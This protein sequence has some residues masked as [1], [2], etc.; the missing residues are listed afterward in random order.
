MLFP[1]ILNFKYKNVVAS[2]VLTFSISPRSN[3]PLVNI[4]KNR[5]EVTL[6]LYIALS[7]FF[8]SIRASRSL[9]ECGATGLDLSID[10]QSEPF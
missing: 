1:A 5:P 2:F 9:C 8:P 4:S 7:F 3:C 6:Q 10:A